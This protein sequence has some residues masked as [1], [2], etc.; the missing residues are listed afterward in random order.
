MRS[1]TLK[2]IVLTATL[3]IIVIV[4]VQLYWL[5]MIYSLEQKTFNINVVKSIRGLYE[6]VNIMDS[7]VN[8]LQD[9]IEHPSPDYFLFR[10]SGVYEKDSLV[11]YLKD[12]LNDFDVLTDAHV[13]FYSSR[14]KK[15][16]SREYVAAAAA[17]YDPVVSPFP[18]FERQYDYVLL[19]FPHRNRYVLQQ[20]N[21][22]FISSVVLFV[23]LI[24][25]A[26]SLFYFYRQKFLAEVQKDFV[27]NFTHEFKTPLA[28]MKIS[29]DVLLQEKI[30]KQPDRLHQYATIIQNQTMHLQKQVERLLQVATSER[31]E[32][33]I[34]RTPVTVNGI[35]EEAVT[36]IQPLAQEKKAVLELQLPEDNN[37]ELLADRAHLELAIVNLLENALK[38]S[39]NPRIIVSAGKENDHIFISV[40]DNG[41]GIDK[42]YHKKLFEKFYR[43][44][45]GDVH[46][47][48]GFG[49]GLSFVKRI[50]DAHHGSIDINSIPGIGTEFR[51]LLPGN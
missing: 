8:H 2:W 19:Y 29:S 47:V 26:V 35:I 10:T 4:G 25:L 3:L 20:M 7:P 42:K 37:Y 43:V 24:G 23:V 14:E 16:T 9:I 44:P 39:P 17:R 36:K 5:N 48:K 12:E 1:K 27:N 50:I 13:G 32:L 28:V 38:Y 33:P 34:Q 11:W 31:K 21:F 6:D 18:V 22:W 51:L 40:K 45:T 46:N 15:Y 41:I 49:L 30:I